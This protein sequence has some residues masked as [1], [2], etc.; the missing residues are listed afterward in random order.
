MSSLNKS[1][2]RSGHA[3]GRSCQRRESPGSAAKPIPDYIF[4]RAGSPAYEDEMIDFS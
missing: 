3:R 2:F 4:G 1:F